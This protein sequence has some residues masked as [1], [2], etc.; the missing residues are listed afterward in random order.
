MVLSDKG[1]FTHHGVQK[2]QLITAVLIFSFFLI[3]YKQGSLWMRI[4]K[5]SLDWRK[6]EGIPKE[7]HDDKEYK[8][9]ENWLSSNLKDVL[10][11]PW[12]D[13]DDVLGGKK[14]SFLS[15]HLNLFDQ[16]L[17][18]GPGILNQSRACVRS[19]TDLEKVSAAEAPRELSLVLTS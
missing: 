14:C 7:G 3:E 10:L 4:P 11:L 1:T 6:R 2:S 8:I 17:F 19:F 5:I 16:I 12:K 18:L 15:S 9:L 13:Y